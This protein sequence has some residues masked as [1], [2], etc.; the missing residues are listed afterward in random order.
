MLVLFLQIKKRERLELFNSLS[1]MGEIDWDG[2]PD[3]SQKLGQ[4]EI[5]RPDLSQIS[6]RVGIGHPDLVKILR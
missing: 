6:G 1:T 4:V 5:G 3:L 2:H